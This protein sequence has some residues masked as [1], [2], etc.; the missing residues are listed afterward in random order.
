VSAQAGQALHQEAGGKWARADA[1]ANCGTC[2]CERAEL[3]PAAERVAPLR[4]AL[5]CYAAALAIEADAEARAAL[6]S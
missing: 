6:S 1:A 5:T 2:L 4:D 3:L